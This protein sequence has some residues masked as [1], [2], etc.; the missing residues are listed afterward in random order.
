[1]N[2]RFRGASK[3]RYSGVTTRCFFAPS[4]GS[5]ELPPTLIGAAEVMG[6]P[7]GLVFCSGSTEVIGSPCGFVLTSGS[8]GLL[9]VASS[10]SL[11]SQALRS[12]GPG[13]AIPTVSRMSMRH[14]PFRGGMNASG[15]SPR[16]QRGKRTDMSL[17]PVDTALQA[18]ITD[19]FAVGGEFHPHLFT[20]PLEDLGHFPE[21]GG[22]HVV[23]AQHRVLMALLRAQRRGATVR[24]GTDHLQREVCIVTMHADENTRLDLVAPDCQVRMVRIDDLL[25]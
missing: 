20:H 12:N 1:M 5:F 6:S 10:P 17:I 4:C 21:L 18:G 19:V 11:L 22:I 16:L 23:D 8:R 2:S 3:N 14:L 9:I 25:R 7:W 13:Y 24:A 15:R